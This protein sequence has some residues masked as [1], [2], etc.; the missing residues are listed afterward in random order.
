MAMNSYNMNTRFAQTGLTTTP[1]ST[2]SMNT[3]FAQTGLTTT[4][5][6]TSS[7]NTRFAQTG[8]TTTPGLT[9]FVCFASLFIG[10]SLNAALRMNIILFP[11]C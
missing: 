5:G 2:S 11:L 3:R 10:G 9:S 6:S 8:L 4:P 7:M 1:G